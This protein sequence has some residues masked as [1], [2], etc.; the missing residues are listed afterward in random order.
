MKKINASIIKEKAVEQGMTTLIEDGIMK[1][2]N[3]DTTIDEIL[4]VKRE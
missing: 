2:L 1:V 4:R 3:G